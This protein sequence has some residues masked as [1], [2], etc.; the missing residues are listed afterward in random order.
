M[1]SMKTRTQTSA[2]IFHSRAALLLTTLVATCT[3][4]TSTPAQCLPAPAG[5]VGWWQGE[6][7]ATDSIGTNHGTFPFGSAFATGQVGQALDFDGVSR[8]VQVP[9]APV[10]NPTNAITLEAWVYMTGPY[11]GVGGAM[12]GKDGVYSDRQYM[13][14]MVDRYQ[15]G[16][17]NIPNSW[18]FRAHLSV[19]G[20]FKILDSVTTI[21]FG[22]WHHVAMTYDGALLSLFVDGKLDASTPLSGPIITTSQPLVIG[23]SVDGPWDFNGRV[24]ELSLY[25]R[26]LS[27]NEITAIHAAGSAGKCA[28]TAPE[29]CIT[30]PSGLAS[31]WS[32]EGNAKDSVSGQNAILQGGAG[33]NAGKVG[34]AF[35]FDGVDD[36]LLING[37]STL[38]V[39]A[40][41]GFTMEGWINPASTS[42]MPIFEFERS[43]GTSEDNDVG[44]HL[45]I[46]ITSLGAGSFYVNLLDTNQ[47][48]HVIATGPGFVQAGIWQHVAV[49]YDK[50][51]GQSQ[52]PTWA[53]S[54]RKPR[55]PTYCS[56]REPHSVQRHPRPTNSPAGWMRSVSTTAR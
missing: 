3:W 10:L 51:S 47:S 15:Q 7:N 9:D 1:N 5:L 23:G 27:A 12:F 8:V 37:S 31:M 24:D 28:P 11:S 34:Q 49:S 18:I 36:Y 39:G 35:S 44:A 16:L 13:V 26:A 30:P 38:D 54:R 53:A 29:T 55:S 14:G 2:C 22:S 56:V 32:A 45:F 48:S 20:E 50:V 41:A 25:H 42:M 52:T 19:P 46:S 43:L 40:G 33:F 17:T 6:S 21:Q 4:V